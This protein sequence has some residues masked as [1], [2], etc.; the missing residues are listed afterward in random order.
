LIVV[1]FN[2]QHG[3]R[4]DGVVDVPS[5]ARACASFGA[6]VLALQ[7]VDDLAV[8]SGN[9]DI[10]AV[11]AEACDMSWVFGPATKLG[12]RG[13]YGNAL[14]VRGEIS[15]VDVVPLPHSPDEEPRSAIVARALGVSIAATHLG[16]RGDATPQLPVAVRALLDRPGPRL[17]LGDLNLTRPDVAPLRLVDAPPAFPASRPRRAIDHVAH[18]DGLRATAVSVLPRQPVSDHRPLRVDVASA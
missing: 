3:R 7:E 14:L 10:A 5:L 12:T 4:P 11:V 8:R 15:D 9:V 18:D 13:R 1:S 6:D 2:I 17:L 16:I